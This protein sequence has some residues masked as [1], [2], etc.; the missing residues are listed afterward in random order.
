MDDRQYDSAFLRTRDMD[1]LVPEPRKMK[2]T[3]NVP[4]LLRDLG[5]VVDF[6]GSK[7][8]MRLNHPD[9]IVEFLVP[10]KG[11]TSNKPYPLPALGMNAAALRFLDLLTENVIKVKVDKYLISLP[12]PI[13]YA[14]QKIIISGRPVLKE[15]IC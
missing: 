15:R 13:N 7:G 10:E 11:R 5:F 1:F 3:S 4:S 2:K 12:H 8:Y 6:Q 9:L 14:L